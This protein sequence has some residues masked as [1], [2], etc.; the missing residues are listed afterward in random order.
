MRSPLRI[1]PVCSTDP[2]KLI[3]LP[4]LDIINALTLSVIQRDTSFIT[5]QPLTRPEAL[6]PA[7]EPG[8][9]LSSTCQRGKTMKDR[10]SK[11]LVVEDETRMRRVITMLLSDMPLEFVEAQ[12]GHQAINAFETGRFDLVITDLKLPKSNGMEVLS[13]IKQKAPHL[14]VII[15]TAFGSAENA[16]SAIRKGA[17]DYI[18]KPFREERL[19][20]CVEKALFVSRLAGELNS[21]W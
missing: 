11:I 12:D 20:E 8:N 9:V 4:E 6:L 1:E 21:K 13:H 3:T 14:P 7:S 19:R 15:I 5:F 16:T 2:V 10:L 17:F 18:T